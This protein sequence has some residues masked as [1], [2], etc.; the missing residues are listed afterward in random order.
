MA[1]EH[2]A[3]PEA[4]GGDPIVDE[5]AAAGFVE[6]KEVGRGGAGVVYRCYQTSLARWVAV[7][8]LA[9]DLDADH[10]ERFLREGYAMGKLSGHPN[11]VNILHV[12]VT[13][14]GRPFIVMTYHAAGSLAQRV[15][16]AGRISWPE[17]LRIGVKLCGALETAHRMGTLHRDIKPANILQTDYSEPQ[18]SDFG[19]ARIV[20]GYET[21]TGYFT[22]TIAY[23]APDVLVGSSPTT[24][25]DVY[26]LGATLYALIAGTN[27][28]DRSTGEEL[29]AQY[30]RITSTPLPDLRP[31]GIPDAVC[32]AIEKA[33]SLNPDQRQASAEEFGHE[34][35]QAQRRNGLNPDSMALSETYPDT[36]TKSTPLR[37]P[38]SHPATTIVD[39][40]EAANSHATDWSESVPHEVSS[41]GPVSSPPQPSW[42]APLTPPPPSS[43]TP[44]PHRAPTPPPNVAVG[45]PVAPLGEPSKSHRT[46]LI[47]GAAALLAVAIVAACVFFIATRDKPQSAALNATSPTAEPQAGWQPIT[48]ARVAREATAT[49]QA[50]G[51]VWIFGGLDSAGSISGRHE[52]YDPAIDNWKGG[53]DLPVPVEGAMAV[54]YQDNPVVLG[55][56]RSEG[57]TPK[58]ATDRVSRVVNSRWTELPPLLQPRAAAA[59]GVVG[60][61]IVVTGGVGAKGQ[62]VTTTEIFDG[63]AWR[64]GAQLPTPRQLVGAATDDKRLY[65]VGGTAGA[66]DLSTVEAYDPAADAWTTLPSLAVPRSDLG[67]TVADGRLVAVGGVSNGKPLPNTS[68]LD[69][70]T[71]TWSE[72]PDLSSGRHG[73]AVAAVGKTVY[74]IGG[75][76]GASDSPVTS[77]AESLTLAPRRTAPS[78]QWRTSP[79]AKTARMMTAWTV[80]D[81]KI[82][83]AG[84]MLGHETTLDTVETFDPKNGLWQSQPSLP[85]PLNHATAATYRG[86]VVVIGGSQSGLADASDQVFVFRNGAWVRLPALKH[87]RAAAAS[88]VVGDKL[89][90]VGGQNEKTLVTQTEIFDGESWQDAAQ[91]PTPREHLAA[92]SDGHYMYTIGGRFLT[93][94][95]NSAAL[96]RFDPQ[97]GQWETLVDM[98]TPRGSYGAVFIDGRIVAVGGE[99]PTQVLATVEMYDTASGKWSTL[100]PLGTPRHGEVVA[101]VDSA[102]YVIGGA[103]RPSHEGAI[104]TVEALDFK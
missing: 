38:T 13:A 20:G 99:E 61:E 81:G 100:T 53:D 46:A 19:I 86:E 62:L 35:Q 3:A 43:P 88:A 80:Q 84:G 28:Y 68:T 23:T 22:G 26:S 6:A 69:L 104:A 9:S 56:W 54:T 49:T 36:P 79:D 2:D 55:G 58:V 27:A 103:G 89:I 24:V 83:I 30:L 75:S 42:F 57:T 78:L 93:A 1:G 70:S 94:D 31:E 25:S 76:T 33:M 91:M 16:R 12:A 97:S 15:H 101:A 74:V 45:P 4:S 29:I 40:A 32:S 66:A 65:A 50:D 63:T 44:Q 59:A 67:V 21:R 95:K 82:W 92:V 52:G 96:E 71:L 14:T 8:V 73:M 98:P 11:I 18:L 102:V 17:A 87:A 72:F 5:L 34:L 64:L 37:E 7:K 47:A 10:R 41:S 77:S 85:I 90:V 51:T 60:N 39:E 48:N